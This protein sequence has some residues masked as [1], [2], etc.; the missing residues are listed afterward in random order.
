MFNTFEEKH[1]VSLQLLRGGKSSSLVQEATANVELGCTDHS[2]TWS[3][4]ADYMCLFLCD[5]SEDSFLGGKGRCLCLHFIFLSLFLLDIS[6]K[7]F[8]GFF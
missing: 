1:L 4:A 3:S 5:V 7:M 6:I 2:S 8:Q